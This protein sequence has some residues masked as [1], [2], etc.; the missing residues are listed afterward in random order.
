MQ[1]REDAFILLHQHSLG[2]LEFES[3]RRKTGFS[4]RP[5]HRG[6]EAAVT[7]LRRRQVDG[8]LDIR[9]PFYRLAAGFPQH[10]FP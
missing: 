4:E 10:P 9:G 7:Q 3:L 5:F 8:D 2:D 1:H 6:H